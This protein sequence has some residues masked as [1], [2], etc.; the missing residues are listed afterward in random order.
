MSFSIRAPSARASTSLS[1][2]FTA[3][4]TGAAHG[5]SMRSAASIPAIIRPPAPLGRASEGV[6]EPALGALAPERGSTG[7]PTNPWADAIVID[8]HSKKPA[9][10]NLFMAYLLVAEFGN[11]ILPSPQ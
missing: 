4:L 11:P 2:I 1:T 6:A 8:A 3:Y 9:K 10:S 7:A 5:L